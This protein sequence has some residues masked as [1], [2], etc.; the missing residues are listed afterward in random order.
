MTTKG[1][2]QSPWS[3]EGLEQRGYKKCPYCWRHLV[4]I[5]Q[6]VEAHRTGRIGP[7]GRRRDRKADVRNVIRRR[8]VGRTALARLAALAPDR[9]LLREVDAA[10]DQEP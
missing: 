7:D 8:W 6:H 9:G 3:H 10:A 4:K 5:D 1:R 2:R